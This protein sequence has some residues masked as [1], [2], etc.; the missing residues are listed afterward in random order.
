[1]FVKEFTRN[2][3]SIFLTIALMCFASYAEAEQITV[4]ATGQ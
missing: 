4:E 2:T 1:M 3:V